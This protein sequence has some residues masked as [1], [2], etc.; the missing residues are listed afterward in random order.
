MTPWP[1]GQCSDTSTHRPDIVCSCVA[2]DPS[3][4]VGQP[5]GRP[6]PR[7]GACQSRLHSAHSGLPPVPERRFSLSM[8]LPVL[9]DVLS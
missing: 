8:L 1:V 2:C 6:T 9:H 3:L 4:E 7:R 5:G